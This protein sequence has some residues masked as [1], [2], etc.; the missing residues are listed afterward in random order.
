MKRIWMVG[1]IGIAISAL[2]L[3]WARQAA[4][5]ADGNIQRLL[6]V[7]APYMQQNREL[8][9]KYTGNYGNC[10]HSDQ[11]LLA[12]QNLSKALDFPLSAELDD[13]NHHP[14][15]SIEKNVGNLSKASLQ[16]IKLENSSSCY[17]VIRL[18]SSGEDDFSQAN[19][20]QKE[21]ERQL[22][23]LKINGQWNFMAK[24]I[25]ASKDVQSE[26]STRAIMNSIL[27]TV[28]GKVVESYTDQGT[29]SL[30]L[31]AKQFKNF[32]KSGE[33]TINLQ[34]AL[35]RNS[36]TGEMRLTVATPVITAEY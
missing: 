13:A 5:T 1:I 19:Q 29:L 32:I 7:T 24:G 30:S 17:L 15:Y 23:K 33:H 10:D 4:A 12:G 22:T 18:V 28:D 36:L 3:G 14:I 2:V 9:I 27:H 11:L 20:W 31:S 16:V 25:V 26:D 35:H 6:E 34:A 21:M 8:T